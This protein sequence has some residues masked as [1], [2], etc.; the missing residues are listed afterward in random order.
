MKNR[1]VRLNPVLQN[2][3]IRLESLLPTNKGFDILLQALNGFKEYD[4]KIY[5]R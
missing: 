2:L 1:N 5:G 4:S 3:F